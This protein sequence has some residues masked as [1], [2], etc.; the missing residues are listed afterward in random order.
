MSAALVV[1]LRQ[2]QI[3]QR[4]HGAGAW[5][6]E[7]ARTPAELGVRENWLFRRLVSRDVL[8]DVGDGRYHLVREGVLRQRRRYRVLGLVS[9]ALIVAA[10]VLLAL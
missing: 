2:K 8:R 6:H 5:G 10:L 1:I 4:F 9:L 3:M 7:T